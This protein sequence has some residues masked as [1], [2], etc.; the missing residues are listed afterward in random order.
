M[1]DELSIKIPV[2]LDTSKIKNDD[3]PKINKELADKTD[4]KVQL[5][6]S[7]DFKTT[8]A[9]IKAQ[10]EQMSKN[11]RI[12]ID[13]NINTATVVENTKRGL[14]DIYSSIGNIPTVDTSTMMKNLKNALGVGGKDIK[15]AYESLKQTLV[16]TPNDVQKI[17]AS[18][19]NLADTIL[20]NFK[21]DPDMNHKNWINLQNVIYEC[22]TAFDTIKTKSDDSVTAIKTTGKAI[23]DTAKG[24]KEASNKM[25]TAMVD[26]SRTNLSVVK[27]DENDSVGTIKANSTSFSSSIP[28]TISGDNVDVVNQL[29]EA[30]RGLGEVSATTNS[31][32]VNIGEGTEEKI[33]DITIQ[34]KSATGEVEKFKYALT[35]IN[36]DG[37][38]FAYVLQNINKADTGVK[39]LTDSIAKARLKAVEDLKI[40]NNASR[41]MLKKDS[42]YTEAESAAEKIVD[43]DSL[44]TF[45]KKFSELKKL[46]DDVSRNFTASKSS[47]NRFENADARISKFSNDIEDIERKAKKIQNIPKELA[48]EISA[49]KTQYSGFKE[50]YAGDGSILKKSE[51]FRSLNESIFRVEETLKKASKESAALMAD[52]RSEENIKRTRD[53]IEKLISTITTYQNAN[54]K[55]MKSGSYKQQTDEMIDALKRLQSQTNL[56][57]KEIQS[58]FQS[59]NR[60]FANSRAEIKAA[61]LEGQTFFEMFKEKVA[62]FSGWMSLTTVISTLAGTFRDAV[63]E[64]KEVD[65]ILTEVSKTSDLTDSQLKDL[66]DTAYNV[67]N[68]YGA[69]ATGYLTGVQE[70]YRAGKENADQLAEISL[71]AQTAGDLTADVANDY[72][73]A[74]DAAYDFKGNAEELTKVL[75]GQNQVTNLNAVSMNDLAAATSEA[76]SMAAQ[77]G[78]QIDQLTALIA[79]ATSRTRESGDETGNA[80]K[81][82]FVN[83]QDTTNKQIV[84]TFEQAGISMTEFVDGSEQL[85]TPIEL[86]KELSEVYN[87]APEG[88]TLKA[89]I[90]SDIGGKYRANTL[91]AMLSG[92]SDYEKILTDYANGSGSAMREAEKTANSW[93]GQLNKLSNS[94]TNLVKNVVDSDVIE[95][96]IGLASSGVDVLDDLIDKLGV[97][98]TLITAVTGAMSFT[99]NK[100]GNELMFLRICPSLIIITSWKQ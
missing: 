39:N 82:L 37:S 51:E 30:Y 59:I 91:A 89:N 84:K 72:I 21:V 78:V 38:E 1:A 64:L 35:D 32:L 66:G 88:S 27:R 23:E 44:N 96:G 87:A 98:P 62:K 95:K 8:Q 5:V 4:V 76:A 50:L 52:K 14:K 80:I 63:E 93:E 18:Y 29:K 43:I 15:E 77:S 13:A 85:K 74:T 3:I 25:K 16:L 81:S 56:T 60:S 9:N 20:D 48:Q 31:K 28:S 54:T 86:L 53:N 45:I 47:M 49:L 70:M 10:I 57:D 46:E 61:G 26:I 36:G 58:A 7:L 79:T 100:G 55:A 83:L 65:T 42:K 97:M 34:V 24:I 92:W 2:R 11:L 68:K 6:G 75:D 69:T 71:L 73:L 12:N 41:G 67:A 19:T 40:L 99:A 33:K 17:E 94:W 90:L 22:A